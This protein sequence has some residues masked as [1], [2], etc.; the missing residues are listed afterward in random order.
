MNLVTKKYGL[1]ISF[2]CKPILFSKTWNEGN[3][4]VSCEIESFL[5]KILSDSSVSKRRELI[6]QDC[7][8]WPHRLE[9]GSAC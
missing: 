2:H 5:I 4:H 9:H 3:F 8:T 1:L 6:I 7:Q